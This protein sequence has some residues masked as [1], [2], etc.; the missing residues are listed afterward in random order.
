MFAGHL[1]IFCT[2]TK[3][4][5]QLQTH[6][7]PFSHHQLEVDIVAWSTAGTEDHLV[8]LATLCVHIEMDVLV[9]FCTVLCNLEAGRKVVTIWDPDFF[10]IAHHSPFSSALRARRSPLVK[11]WCPAY[12]A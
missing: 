12:L 2:Q 3:F 8:R 10:I 4:S 1:A 9:P 7:A 11:A 5:S 6:A